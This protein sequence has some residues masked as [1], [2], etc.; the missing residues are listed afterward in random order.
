VVSKEVSRVLLDLIA[1][2]EGSRITYYLLYLWML[3]LRYLQP[4]DSTRLVELIDNDSIRKN[5]RTTIPSPYRESDALDFIHG[6]SPDRGQH[7]YGI[8]IDDALIGCIGL[9][10]QASIYARSVELGYWIGESYWGSGYATA[11]VR[12]ALEKAWV[13]PD[14]V[15]LFADVIEYNHA[16]MRV[17]EKCGFAKE[18]V[19]RQA[20][21]KDG[22]MYDEHRYAILKP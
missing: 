13:I 22:A 18:G 20:A 11:A 14:I 21:W 19:A 1:A 17:L 10:G 12:L 6:A 4:D 7:V 3:T 15:R 8:V 2:G 16:S 9:H 5:L